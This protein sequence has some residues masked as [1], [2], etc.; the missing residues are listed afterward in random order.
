MKTKNLKLRRSLVMLLGRAACIIWCVGLAMTIV[1]TNTC[2]KTRS[3]T[4][5]DYSGI[6]KSVTSCNDSFFPKIEA[7]RKPYIS[8]GAKTQF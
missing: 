8:N 5:K 2:Q 1:T 7:W 6:I 4:L 3:S